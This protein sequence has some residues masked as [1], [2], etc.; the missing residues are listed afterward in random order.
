MIV[1]FAFKSFQ[2]HNHYRLSKIRIFLQ[3]ENI[4]GQYRTGIPSTN[5]FL[6]EKG[7]LSLIRAIGIS[8]S[9]V[10]YI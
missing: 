2:W 4:P 8:G 10:R 5:M 7:I 1:S 9:A 6:A 3:H